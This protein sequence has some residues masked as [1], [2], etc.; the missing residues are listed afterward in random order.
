MTNLHQVMGWLNQFIISL[1]LSYWTS[2]HH[3]VSRLLFFFVKTKESLNSIISTLT[4][5]AYC[6][7]LFYSHKIV[8]KSIHANK[9]TCNHIEKIQFWTAVTYLRAIPIYVQ[10]AHP[11]YV[12]SYTFTS[13]NLSPRNN[14]LIGRLLTGGGEVSTNSA[15]S[16]NSSRLAV[17][18]FH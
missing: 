3:I 15:N 10:F 18:I 12:G 5:F 16:S 1:H 9:Y 4:I 11:F 8:I 2:Y 17:R 13:S 7:N 14:I 6:S